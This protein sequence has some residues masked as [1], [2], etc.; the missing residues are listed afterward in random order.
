MVSMTTM[1]T[2]RSPS[3][4]FLYL[5]QALEYCLDVLKMKQ[6]IQKNRDSAWSSSNGDA[7]NIV[8]LRRIS[9]HHDLHAYPRDT[10]IPG[11]EE[12]RSCGNKTEPILCVWGVGIVIIVI[13]CY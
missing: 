8:R 2:I 3:D 9:N 13:V 1:T 7:G 10:T 6:G 11:Y 5:K 4:N 12:Y